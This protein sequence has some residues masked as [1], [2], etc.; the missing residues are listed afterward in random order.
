MERKR[1][2]EGFDDVPAKRLSGGAADGSS[3]NPYTGRPYSQKYY[4]I[5]EKRTGALD[6]SCFH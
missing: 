5:L 4:D 3:V 6:R 1:K 2:L